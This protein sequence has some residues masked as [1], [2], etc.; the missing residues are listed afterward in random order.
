MRTLAIPADSAAITVRTEQLHSGREQEAWMSERI[1]VVGHC[2][3]SRVWDQTWTRPGKGW[4]RV[5]RGSGG[6][7]RLKSDEFL[8]DLGGVVEVVTG[9]VRDGGPGGGQ[10]FRARF[11]HLAAGRA[12]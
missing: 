6:M 7:P 2:C 1:F 3:T 9:R 10:S 4:S 12:S 11:L 8:Q 5:S